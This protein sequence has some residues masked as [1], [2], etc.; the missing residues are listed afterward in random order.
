MADFAEYL[1]DARKR[2]GMNQIELA[3]RVGL[4]GSY[5]SV[6]E[7]RKKPPPSDKVLRRLADALEVSEDEM[8]EVAHLDKSPDDIRDRIRALDRSLHKLAGLQ[9][10]HMRI[11]EHIDV[12]FQASV[13]I[14]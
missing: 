2:A 8:I 7:G 12:E 4:T 1:R 9:Y 13:S 11:H 6:L 14:V 3:E 10:V 5:I